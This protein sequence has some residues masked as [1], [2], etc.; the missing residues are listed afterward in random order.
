MSSPEE[1]SPAGPRRLREA[2]GGL[3][4]GALSVATLAAAFVLSYGEAGQ[5]GGGDSTPVAAA[6]TPASAVATRAPSNTAQLPAGA[7]TPAHS[8]TTER[9]ATTTA[10]SAPSRTSTI[11]PSSTPTHSALTATQL[12]PPSATSSPT[13]TA[14]VQPLVVDG[15]EIPGG[16][17]AYTVQTGDTLFRLSQRAGAPVT[18]LQQGNCLQGTSLI[19]GQVVYLPMEAPPPAACGPPAGWGLYTV[20][21]GDTLFNMSQRF[22]TTVL[23]LQ[24]ANCFGSTTSIRVGALIYAPPGAA[25]AS[26]EAASPTATPAGPAATSGPTPVL[27]FAQTALVVS[28]GDGAATITVTRAG[29]LSQPSGVAYLTVGGSAAGGAD[30]VGGSGVLSFGAGVSSQSFQLTL[31]DDG[32]VESDETVIISLSD[33]TNATIATG[34]SITVTITDNDPQVSFA[35]SATVVEEANVDVEFT[36]VLSAPSV[37]EVQVNFRTIASNA[38]AGLDFDAASG[39]ITFE[40]QALTKT[41]RFSIL[42]DDAVEVQESFGVVLESP[43]NARLGAAQA[44]TVTILDNDAAPTVQFEPATY[45]VTEGTPTVSLT[46]TLSG[47]SVNLVT[48]NYVPTSGAADAGTDFNPST[49]SVSF[50]PHET[51]KTFSIQVFDDS[52]VEADEHFQ[53]SLSGA[54]NAVLGGINT[55]TVTIVDNDA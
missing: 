22:G 41:L 48:V 51:S 36:V 14:T 46:I 9:K 54:S 44:A 23:A 13:S 32:D 17:S 52:E 20:Q 18:A 49:G 34:A 33:A 39:T 47:A 24:Q 37:V 16:W 4:V 21:R 31:L 11:R 26:P 1:Q 27:A 10:S 19:V 25:A 15:C 29:D 45:V 8:P 12:Q 50:G 7:V 30:F 35:A 55:A 28:E 6:V 42:D 5:L 40:P 43:V 53:V 2:L 3:L 38:T